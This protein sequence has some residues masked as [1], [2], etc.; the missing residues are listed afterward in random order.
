MT[1]TMLGALLQTTMSMSSQAEYNWQSF[2]CVQILNHELLVE[3][4]DI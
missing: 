3:H 4:I 1:S 2:E